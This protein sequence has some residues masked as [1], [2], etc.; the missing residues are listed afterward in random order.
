MTG[1]M[2]QS[3]VQE[4]C[5]APPMALHWKHGSNTTNRADLAARLCI[6][7]P[8]L[9]GEPHY[10]LRFE[11][12]SPDGFFGVTRHC[13]PDRSVLRTSSGRLSGSFSQQRGRR[14]VQS[15]CGLRWHVGDRADAGGLPVDTRAAVVPHQSERTQRERDNRRPRASSTHRSRLSEA[16]RAGPAPHAPDKTPSR[17]PTSRQ[18]HCIY[19]SNR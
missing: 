3:P 6:A 14:Q 19:A 9:R 8:G 16:C 15:M 12:P 4:V 5:T 13:R 11:P 10:G 2:R 1:T 18:T 17:A 7:C